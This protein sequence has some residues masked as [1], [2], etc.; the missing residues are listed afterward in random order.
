MGLLVL[1]LLMTLGACVAAALVADR[2]PASSNAMPPLRWA[3]L[4]WSHYVH[5]S[6]AQG[7]ARDVAAV[8]V[9]WWH[10]GAW[11]MFA[12]AVLRR[13]GVLPELCATCAGNGR[14]MARHGSTRRTVCSDC[15]GTK[16]ARRRA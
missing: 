8:V 6:H 11:L 15:H 13:W 4:T 5:A 2:L 7:T 16:Y 10:P 14:L 1:A 9:R 3:G 12:R